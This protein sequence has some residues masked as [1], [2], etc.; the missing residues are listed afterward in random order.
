MQRVWLLPIQGA[1]LESAAGCLHRTALLTTE[2]CATSPARSSARAN[3]NG[4]ALLVSINA[5]FFTLEV[6][7][8]LLFF[9]SFTCGAVRAGAGAASVQD[10][11]DSSDSAHGVVTV[12]G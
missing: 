1:P 9:S 10:R 7:D 8:L 5:T 12:S 11:Y 4:L 6:L 2:Y 3:K